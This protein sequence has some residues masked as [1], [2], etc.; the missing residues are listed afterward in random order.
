MFMLSSILVSIKADIPQQEQGP[1]FLI[2]RAML[3]V[4][5]ISSMEEDMPMFLVTCIGLTDIYMVLT[6]YLCISKEMAKL[7][8]TE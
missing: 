5:R 4:S 1:F 7:E 3:P 8:A 6:R 2:L